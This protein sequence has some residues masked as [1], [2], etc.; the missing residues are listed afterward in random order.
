MDKKENQITLH[1]K[2]SSRIADSTLWIILILIGFA[3][4]AVFSAKTKPAKEKQNREMLDAN[5]T[6]Q[7]ASDIDNSIITKPPD[8]RLLKKISYAHEKT[9]IEQNHNGTEYEIPQ[10]YLRTKNIRN[11][12]RKKI[13]EN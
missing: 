4:M 8:K 7:K 1:E 6:K 13:E 3:F 5:S 2:Y 9:E 12:I 10:K 11:S